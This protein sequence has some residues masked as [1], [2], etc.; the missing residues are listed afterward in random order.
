MYVGLSPLPVTVT[1]KGLI[2]IPGFPIKNVK[3]LVVTVTGRG[4]NPRCTSSYAHIDEHAHFTLA[5]LVEVGKSFKPTIPNKHTSAEGCKWHLVGHPKLESMM[6]RGLRENSKKSF[7][8]SL[9]INM[10]P[11]NHPT[12]KENH[13]P[14]TSIFGF[15]MLNFRSVNEMFREFPLI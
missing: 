10:E 14:S 12:E 11:K 5:T 1:N 9:K 15:N 13:L 2:G 8:T 4:D 3:I 6:T 7:D